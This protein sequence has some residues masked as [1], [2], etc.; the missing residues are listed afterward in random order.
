MY[1]EVKGQSGLMP[2]PRVGVG[3]N[4]ELEPRFQCGERRHPSSSS[5]TLRVFLPTC[6]NIH[7]TLLSSISHVYRHSPA[8]AIQY[9]DDGFDAQS[10]QGL[11]GAHCVPDQ[12]V[13]H[14]Y[15]VISRCANQVTD[16]IATKSTFKNC[17]SLVSYSI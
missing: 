15:S 11:S 14:A 6:R 13:C 3:V 4:K 1:V 2:R 17:P 10:S 5:L 7:L 9:Q 12:E 8:F 16:I